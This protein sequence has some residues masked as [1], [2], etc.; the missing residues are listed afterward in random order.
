M[1]SDDLYEPTIARNKLKEK[2][3]QKWKQNKTKEKRITR[4]QGGKE[5]QPL[6]SLSAELTASVKGELQRIIINHKLRE[7]PISWITVPLYQHLELRIISWRDPTFPTREE[8]LQ[9]NIIL[10]R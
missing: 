9:D 2:V 5:G 1:Q 7:L 3:M 10:F 4:G 8:Q 6:L